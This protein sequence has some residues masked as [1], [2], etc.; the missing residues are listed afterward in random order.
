MIIWNPAANFILEQVAQRQRYRCIV[1]GSD[2]FNGEALPVGTEEEI[3]AWIAARYKVIGALFVIDQDYLPNRI[4]WNVGESTWFGSE[5]WN[6]TPMTKRYLVEVREGDEGMF[7]LC[8]V[9]DGLLEWHP[10]RAL[11]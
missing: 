7:V 8:P 6:P 2:M 5:M 1:N 9:P 3:L 4:I 11:T 10:G